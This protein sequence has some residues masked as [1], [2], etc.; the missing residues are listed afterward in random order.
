MDESRATLKING[1]NVTAETK[2]RDNA[3]EAWFIGANNS[4]E[5]GNRGRT[6]GSYRLHTYAGIDEGLH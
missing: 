6:N 1:H 2:K 4:Q 3:V 5:D